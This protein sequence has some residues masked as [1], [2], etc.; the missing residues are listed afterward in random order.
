[1]QSVVREWKLRPEYGDT[2]WFDGHRWL[3][4]RRVEAG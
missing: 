4:R 3:R 2:N 1:M